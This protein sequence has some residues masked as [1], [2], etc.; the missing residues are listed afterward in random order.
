MKLATTTGDFSNYTVEQTKAM[1]YCATAGFRYLDYDFGSDFRRK[2]G[3]FS[4][5]DLDAYADIIKRKADALGVRFIQSHAPMGAPIAPDNAQFIKDNIRCIDFCAKLGI[6]KIVIH[7]GYEPG[8]SPEQTFLRN[9]DFFLPLLHHAEKYGINILVENFN[10]RCIENL[11]WIDNA[12]DLLKMIECVDHPL[13]HAVW[14]AGHANMQ[15][16]P[17]DEEL[18]ILGK[19]VMALHVQDNMG[20]DDSHIAPYFG[21][22]SLD[23]LMHGLIDIGYNGY[24]TFEATNI[25]LSADKR[26]P[27]EKDKRVWK[28]PIDIRIKAENLLYEIGKSVLCAYNCFEE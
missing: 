12:T 3:A 7:S 17:Q 6:D 9:R 24:F 10:I 25:L 21:T 23:S 18:K 4:N 15:K 14:D 2:N 19:H 26:R 5:E 1:E 20:N 11:Y 13:F 27:Y 8:L 22:L 28:A 16:M